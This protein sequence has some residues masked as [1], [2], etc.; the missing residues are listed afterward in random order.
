M[1][2]P[3]IENLLVL[4]QEISVD[5][6]EIFDVEHFHLAM[7]RILFGPAYYD[8]DPDH[9]DLI[10]RL[11]YQ[12]DDLEAKI[13]KLLARWKI[14]LKF[15]R[16]MA[17]GQAGAA[18][19]EAA[20]KRLAVW[21]AHN[22]NVDSVTFFEGSDEEKKLQALSL[23][24]K[25]NGLFLGREVLNRDFT[26]FTHAPVFD[27]FIQKDPFESI[28]QQDTIYKMRLLE[29]PRGSFKSVADG[30]DCVQWIICKPDVRI[31]FLTATLPLAKD[32]V[33]EV[34][35][36][37]TADHHDRDDEERIT[38]FQYIFGNDFRPERARN[39]DGSIARVN[40]LI[41]P[42]EDGK[43]EEF[44]CPARTRGDKKKKE[45]TIWAGSVGAGKVGKHCDVAKAD[46]A[47]D[48]KNSETPALISKT[49]K[50]IGMAFKLV[51]PGRF[52]DNIGT[53]YASN[54]WYNHIH[55][56]VDNVKVLIRPAKWLRKDINGA[57]AIDRGLTERDLTDN[58]WTLLFPCDKYGDPKLTHEQLRANQKEDPDGFPSQY[59]LNPHGYKKISFSDALIFQQTLA[60]PEDLPSQS[61]PYVTYILCDL[62]D[63]QNAQSDYSV[64]VVL[65]VDQ[66][67]RGYVTHIYR[68]RFTFYDICYTIAKAN[69]DH[70]PIQILIENSRGADKLKG[71]M[72]R[73]A[74]DMGDRNIPLNFIPVKNVKAAKAIR[75]GKLETRLRD[76][77]LFFCRTI[78]CYEDLV[79]EFRDFGSD[80][81]DDIPDAIGF[82]ENVLPALRQTPQNQQA[83][84]LARRIMNNK[85]FDEMIYGGSPEDYVDVPI[86]P[87]PE[88]EA[89]GT[90]N[91]L[92]GDLWDPFS[93][94]PNRKK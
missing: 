83:A 80:P 62:A 77:M 50:R 30:I 15:D 5:R 58:D 79:R 84:E 56:N 14:Y 17:T 33:K 23:A 68:D 19:V 9:P 26:F 60:T 1:I 92:A 65:K 13:N 27:F 40:F 4:A 38:L 59:M 89:S 67:G 73:A 6:Q 31:V 28:P 82:C 76:H 3:K 8:G 52:K 66:E 53:P 16:H 72:I 94:T 61:V 71:D 42:R 22:G 2:E 88:V 21:N 36:Y 39:K 86:E 90:G 43:E 41:S 85:A 35:G 46:D 34:K 45:A 63:T 11:P 10:T 81:H 57:T 91:D 24:C 44:I 49:K 18:A 7:D 51:D 20:K 32:F 78:E 37:F 93:V 74:L 48:E 87:I 29:M 12:P 47:V 25:I 69:H 55:N 64:F 70:K 54:D 75:I